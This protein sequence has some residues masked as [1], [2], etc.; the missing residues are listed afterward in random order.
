MRYLASSGITLAF[1]VAS[2]HL[3]APPAA[4]FG[5][6][7]FG[8]RGPGNHLERFLETEADLSTPSATGGYM[9][10]TVTV[11]WTNAEGDAQSLSIPTVLT[12]YVPT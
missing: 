8:P 11:T 7:P 6:P 12:E 2:L 10:V 9:N 4:A 3:L 5:G 1:V